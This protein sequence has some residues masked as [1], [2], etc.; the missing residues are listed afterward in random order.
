MATKF[1]L[2]AVPFGML[3]L[4]LRTLSLRFGRLSLFRLFAL[5]ELSPIRRLVSNHT[6][7]MLRA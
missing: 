1:E 5:V 2:L 6:Q 3:S 7:A 4:F